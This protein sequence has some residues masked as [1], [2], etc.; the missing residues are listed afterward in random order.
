M[1]RYSSRR[2]DPRRSSPLS[3]R[4]TTRK[5]GRLALPIAIPT[6]GAAFVGCGLMVVLL[7]Q[8][9]GDA[10]LW[11]FGVAASLLVAAAVGVAA[12]VQAG[13]VGSRV[14]ELGLAVAKIGRG[15]AEVRVRI[16]GDD[17][18]GEL[19][20]AVQ[21]L[22]SDIGALV[23]EIEQGGGQ[24]ANRDPQ[25]R[26]YRDKTLDDE[27]GRPE[28]YEVDGAVCAGGRGGMDYF[29]CV[30]HE[31]QSVVYTVG[32]EG[33]GP[34]S[35]VAA[36]LARD[37]LVRA[38]SAGRNARKA[39]AHTNKVLHERMPRGVCAKA[40]LLEL[41]ADAAKLYQAG[42]KTPLWICQAGEVLELNADGIAL[43]LDAGPVFEKGLRSEKLEMRGGTRLVL[44]NEAGV[45]MQEMLDL[46]EEH[47]PKHTAPF[48]N[49]VLGAL[50]SDAGA[51]GL[52]EDV[53][54]VTA[55]KS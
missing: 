28:G 44:T 50:E 48:M 39:L 47:S 17:E 29:G 18:I 40:S 54:L 16:S 46:V 14:T 24:A 31:S 7:V 42:D 11:A 22:A 32:G 55:K 43:G 9:S 37:E 6:G 25:S 41:H 1:A 34:M 36:R 13:K 33:T 52:R 51:E 23:A 10:K 38:L 8:G 30:E 53:L 27:F 21:Y 20:R 19:G 4:R 26:A 49:L 12:A 5:S 3:R 35:V 15:S 2:H 45:R